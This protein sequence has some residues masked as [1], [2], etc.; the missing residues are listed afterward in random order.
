[1]R[2]MV[3]SAHLHMCCSFH[4]SIQPTPNP[5]PPPQPPTPTQCPLHPSTVEEVRGR[6]CPRCCEAH[7][8]FHH[9]DGSPDNHGFQTAGWC[10]GLLSCANHMH[11]SRTL[12]PCTCVHSRTSNSQAIEPFACFRLCVGHLHNFGHGPQL[13]VGDCS[14]SHYGAGAR[15]L[16]GVPIWGIPGVRQLGRAWG[17]CCQE[18]APRG[19]CCTHSEP[20]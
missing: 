3:R 16:R 13:V 5:P 18:V 19:R 17:F 20:P 14:A 8:C 15:C 7:L 1:M 12:A 9:P 4:S 6:H 2:V 10:S 11:T